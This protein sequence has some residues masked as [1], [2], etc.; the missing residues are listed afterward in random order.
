MTLD[1]DR[2]ETTFAQIKDHEKAFTAAFYDRLFA[3]YPDVK[4]LFAHA[5]MQQQGEKLFKSLVFVVENLR[6]PAV[7][8]NSLKA[9]GTRHVKY[10][11][12]PSHY[13]MVGG[14]LLKTFE[15]FLGPAWDAAAQQ[16]WVKAY[17]AVTQIMLDGEGFDYDV[18]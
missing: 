17:Q 7:L 3:D 13:P 12:L 11:V 8:D 2:L 16:A 15:A 1:I 10:G 14:A 18:K 9:L 4:P 6:Q 5:Q